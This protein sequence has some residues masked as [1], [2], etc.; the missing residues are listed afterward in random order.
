MSN[1]N[2]LVDDAKSMI[3]DLVKE[4]SARKERNETLALHQLATDT[5][6]VRSDRFRNLRELEQKKNQEIMDRGHAANAF[7]QQKHDINMVSE[8]KLDPET[9]KLRYG[10]SSNEFKSDLYDK[11]AIDDAYKSYLQEPANIDPNTGM[12]MTR[13]AFGKQYYSEGVSTGAGTPLANIGTNDMSTNDV[14]EVAPGKF[15]NDPSIIARKKL[16]LINEEEKQREA[17]LND[18]LNNTQNVSDVGLLDTD[19]IQQIPTSTQWTK[20]LARKYYKAANGN[21]ELANKLAKEDGYS[22]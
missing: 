20:E 22:I 14:E 11:K 9:F 3:R 17:P 12:H 18:A 15:T 5:Q 10:N 16:A 7:L 2:S 19:A 6:N 21:I 1:F 13:A 8:G 4:K